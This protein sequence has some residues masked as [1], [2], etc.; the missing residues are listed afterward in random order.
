MTCAEVMK[1]LESLG[2]EQ[3]RK[4]YQRHGTGPNLFGVSF[5]NLN[6]IAKKIKKDHALAR[7]LWATGNADAR[8][9]ALLIADPAATTKAELDGW[10][11]P[12]TYY[13]L[14]DLL[15]RHVAS[16]TPFARELMTKW[17]ASKQEYVQQA[18]WNM[19]AALAMNDGGLDDA[20]LAGFVAT[21]ESRIHQAPNRAR[22][23]MSMALIAIGIRNAK[24]E[25]LAV[26]AAKRIGPVEVDHGETSCQTP[27]VV[28]YIQRTKAHRSRKAS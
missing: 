4:I 7:E 10:L 14:P 19:V 9:L 22:H 2:T 27:D 24:L 17:I 12:V 8:S 26:A 20:T 3:N 23:A 25:K 18:G 5:A 21:I 16:K 15:V 11:K 6:K 13:L 28:S 1:Q